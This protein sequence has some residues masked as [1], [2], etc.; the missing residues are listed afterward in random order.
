MKPPP[1]KRL[2]LTAP[3]LCGGIL[4]VLRQ[5]LSRCSDAI[6]SRV[7]EAEVPNLLK[8]RPLSAHIWLPHYLLD[9]RGAH[10]ACHPR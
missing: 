9:N 6:L 8:G 1:N 7:S 5:P 10:G 3:G 4:F 2:K